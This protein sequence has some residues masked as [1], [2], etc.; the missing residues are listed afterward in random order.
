MKQPGISMERKGPV[1]LF[2]KAGQKPHLKVTGQGLHGGSG[3]D[4]GTPSWEIPGLTPYTTWCFFLWVII[5]KKSLENTI[6]TYKYQG[7][8]YVRGTPLLVP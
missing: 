5:P 6:N 8:T 2:K 7:Y 3:G 1:A 4:L